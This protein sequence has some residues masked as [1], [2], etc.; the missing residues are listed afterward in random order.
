LL[1]WSFSSAAATLPEAWQHEQLLDVPTP[2][3]IKLS[4]PVETLDAARPGLEDLRLYDDAGSEVPYAL[5]RPRQAGKVSQS[6]AS[7]EVSLNATATVLTMETGLALPLDGVT[8]DTPAD[9]FIKSV[10]IE[11]SVDGS[12]WL[13]LAQGQP[14]F[15][16]PSGAGHIRLNVS[17]GVWR[18]LRLTV[19]DRR[20]QPIPF[21]GARLHAAAAEPAPSEALPVAIAER[22]ENPGETRLTLSLGGA[23]LD[24]AAFRLE[25]S[26]PLFRRQVTLAV[27]EISEAAIREQT[28]AQGVIYRVAVDGQPASA[29]L[30]V[31]L[32]CSVHS[33]ELLVLIRNF[34]NPPLP[35]EAVGLERRPVYLV[36]MARSA[37][38]YRLLTGNP[39]CAA[40][41]YD[42]AAVGASLK[43][44]A[45][46]PLKPGPLADNPNHRAPEVLAGIQETG[47]TLDV[48]AW[49]FRKAVKLQG[50]GAQQLELDIDVL[51]RA[52]PGFDDLRLVRDGKQLPYILERTSISR[53][54]A[55]EVKA[56]NGA[57]EPN[58]SRW[59]IKLPR[60][61]LP[62]A[63]L[64]C[65]AGTTLFR[66][67]MILYEEPA[68]E[69]GERHQR[70]L[71]GTTWLRTPD[72]ESKEFVLVLENSPQ[73]DTLFLETHNG[74]NPP[75]ILE[76]FQLFYPATR[77]IFKAR[78]GEGLFLFY[79]NPEAAAPQ[80]DLGLVAG[81]LLAAQKTSASL[82]AE[83]RLKK[84][85]RSEG[86]ARGQLGVLFWTVLGLVVAVLLLIISRLLPKASQRE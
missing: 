60:A 21:T 74:D 53:P 69:R 15:R 18:S 10:Q 85:P 34:D 36:F 56:M 40:P 76:K 45:V 64:D 2:G 61:R 19:D 58:I 9:A 72:R 43:S 54:L 29:N 11:G 5:E 38:A 13:T 57:K 82:A 71:G 73:T 32:D 84:A 41:R 46:S 66:R 49:R 55:P 63:R 67:E 78:S 52:Q 81:Q 65:R 62:L 33:R 50:P 30:A 47:T 7:F 35:I 51:S 23:N 24:L 70:R 1:V 27:P 6:P 75:L 28:V 59:L 68:D 79:G 16:E 26:E 14:I 42:L 20:S 4:L 25:T 3:L 48:S 44:T 80:Y 12:R 83:E 37:G 77:A 31:P 8:L 39:H 22:H 17:P 86:Y